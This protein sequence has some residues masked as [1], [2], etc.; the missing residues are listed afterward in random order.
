MAGDNNAR[1]RLKSV[2]GHE[3]LDPSTQSAPFDLPAE[4]LEQIVARASA[5]Q[6]AA[7]ESSGRKMSEDEIVSIAGEVGLDARHVRRAIAEVRAE[8]LT[9]RSRD[10]M[11]WLSK[12]IG[13]PWVRVKRVID[14]DPLR[15]KERVEARLRDQ[16]QLR[17]I[18][19]GKSYAV[20]TADKSW[21]RRLERSLDM[22]GHGHELAKFGHLELVAAPVGPG[23]SLLTLTLDI[24][25]VRNGHAMGWGM[26][27]GM[28]ALVLG[29]G[30]AGWLA[31]PAA[32]V[33][34]GA[35]T[36]LCRATLAYQR[37]RIALELEGLLDHVQVT[38]S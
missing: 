21:L 31:I 33:A 4:Q 11:P 1:P 24:S 16:E 14:G 20:W 9:P 38:G 19:K 13:P 35:A 12:L 32:L 7:G 3:E 18:R 2:D 15:L 5:L 17:P 23:S 34:L 26:G 25:E 6:Y 27:L 8:A 28:P 22:S 29:Y 36:I 10:L 37:Q 30:L